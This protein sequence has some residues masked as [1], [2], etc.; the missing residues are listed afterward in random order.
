MGASAVMMAIA[1]LAGSFLPHELLRWL[2][3]PASGVLPVLVQLM[4]ALYL[5]FAMV[6]WMARDSL[7]G[8]IYNRPLAIGNLLHFASGALALG[9]YAA[10]AH[11]PPAVIGVT[12]VYV[13]FAIGFAKV[14]FTSPVKS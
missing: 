3:L 12:I 8:G 4:A 7:I 11:P 2:G 6:N 5:G 14:M 1:G 9:K 10:S 13:V